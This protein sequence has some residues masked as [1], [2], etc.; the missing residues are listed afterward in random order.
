[1][2]DQSLAVSRAKGSAA[3]QQEDR[4]ENG[5]LAGPVLPGDE[6]ELGRELERSGFNAAQVFDSQLGE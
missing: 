2:P 3:T 4:L 6:I 1:M 5:S